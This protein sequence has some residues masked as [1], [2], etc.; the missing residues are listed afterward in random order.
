MHMSRDG[1]VQNAK[2]RGFLPILHQI[3]MSASL[4]AHSH[5]KE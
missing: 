2:E 3:V 1:R 4:L 5:V